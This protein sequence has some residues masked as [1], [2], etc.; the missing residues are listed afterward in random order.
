MYLSQHCY[1]VLCASIYVGCTVTEKAEITVANTSTMS[2]LT[3]I[4]LLKNEFCV[5]YLQVAEA[6]T[7]C[8]II[9]QKG[10]HLNTK[11]RSARR[12]L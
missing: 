6:N 1:R 9:W 10:C 5:P 4:L 12:R 2:S 11:L 7:L 3:L 8:L